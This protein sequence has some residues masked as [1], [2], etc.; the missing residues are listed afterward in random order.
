MATDHLQQAIGLLADHILFDHPTVPG[1]CIA[2]H[3]GDGSE[4][5]VAR[6][7]SDPATG[8]PLAPDHAVRIASC[9]KTFVAS[10]LLE[11]AA[12]HSIDLDAPAIDFASPAAAELLEQFEHGRTATLRH[13]LQHRSG[14][15][16]HT[17]FPEFLGPTDRAWTA[18]EQLAIAVGK[19]ASA[20][21]EAV[22]N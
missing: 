9:T 6:G 17:L 19:P 21:Y 5:A 15:V 16:D 1:V 4:L 14:M 22:T 18:L 2:V 12:R 11:L 20:G 10:T 13:F 3:F 7:A 8:T